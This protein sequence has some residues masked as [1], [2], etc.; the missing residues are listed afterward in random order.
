MVTICV[1]DGIER[2]WKIENDRMALNEFGKIAEKQWLELPE[3][4]ENVGLDV[5]VIMPNHVHGIIVIDGVGNRLACSQKENSKWRNRRACSLQKERQHQKLPVIIGSYK[6]GATRT[7][8]CLRNDFNFQWQKSFYDHIIR[9]E[10]SLRG[11]KGYITHNPLK[12][13]L[14]IENKNNERN[15]QACSL[16]RYYESIFQKGA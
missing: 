3:H 2:L 11:I 6:A 7:I 16:Q 12:W 8:N 5:F 14:D 9:N 10:K 1:R 15:R 4:F 13:D